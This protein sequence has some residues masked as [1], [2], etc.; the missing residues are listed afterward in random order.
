MAKQKRPAAASGAARPT[1]LNE[2]SLSAL[3]AKIDK[4]LGK[5]DR[6]EVATKSKKRKH[7]AEGASA[8]PR[9]RKKQSH[10][11]LGAEKNQDGSTTK[12]ES[13]KGGALSRSALLEEIRALGGDEDDL[14]LIEDVDSDQDRA[15]EVDG[16]ESAVDVKLQSDLLA[17][18]AQLG[19]QEYHEH[20]T[21]EEPDQSI[22][23]NENDDTTD[24][25]KEQTTG[26]EEGEQYDNDFQG[27]EPSGNGTKDAS[28]KQFV[29]MPFLSLDSRQYAD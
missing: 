25:V 24:A 6:E 2:Q 8:S 14:E 4:S 20:T 26:S 29:S 19:L 21:V 7:A 18:A 17:F 28:S 10:G 5:G 13:K 15:S 9:Q 22:E 16:P 23:D 27:R 1:P 11:H 12:A 3:T